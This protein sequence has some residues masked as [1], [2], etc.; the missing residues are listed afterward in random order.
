MY[1]IHL[2]VSPDKEE[3][4]KV[5]IY[6]YFSVAAGRRQLSTPFI[7]HHDERVKNLKR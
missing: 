5:F 3:I 1:I 2:Q 7:V 6:I 4:H